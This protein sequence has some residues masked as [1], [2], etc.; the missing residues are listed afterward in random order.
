MT[1]PVRWRTIQQGIASCQDC[2]RGQH[3]LVGSPLSV[4][5]IP[6]PPPTID[7]LFVGVAPTSLSGKHK[8]RH[9]WSNVNDPLRIG[10]FSV[11]DELIDS[12]LRA[13]NG[14]S[15]SAAD[16]DFCARK[17][18]FV[19]SCKVRPVPAKLKAPPDN[20]VAACARRH[21]TEE[22]VS[23]RP[24]AV[25]FLG[26]NTAP[27]AAL[28]GLWIDDRVATAELKCEAGEWNG[29]GMATV[30]PVRGAER[31]TVVAMRRL[32][33]KPDCWNAHDP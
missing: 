2:I 29:L 33:L 3:E 18:F 11:L 13:V 7:V 22:I 5:E 12:R 25:C 16:V 19:H 8:G 20:V 23:L 27:A 28:L 32:S 4:G 21:L 9:F 10:L 17:F 24:R 31:R 1:E 30:Q 15:K 26:Y 6:D 14:H